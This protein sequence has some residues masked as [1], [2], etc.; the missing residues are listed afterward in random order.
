MKIHDYAKGEKSLLVKNDPYVGSFGVLWPVN[1]AVTACDGGWLKYNPRVV[2]NRVINRVA[3]SLVGVLLSYIEDFYSEKK[4]T[5]EMGQWIAAVGGKGRDMVFQFCVVGKEKT[6][7]LSE[8]CSECLRYLVAH[9][10]ANQAT[11]D[12]GRKAFTLAAEKVAFL[13]ARINDLQQDFS[14]CEIQQP[15][16]VETCGKH[17]EIASFRER[18]DVYTGVPREPVPLSGAAIV[19]GFCD[20]ENTVLLKMLNERGQ[21]EERPHRFVVVSAALIDVALEARRSKKHVLFKGKELYAIGAKKPTFHLEELVAV[22]EGS[23]Y[24]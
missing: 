6:P 2:N 18:F 4:V 10:Q 14:G 19:D 12:F 3:A 24:S 5:I 1:Q 20:S 15:F 21:A 13:D 22:K 7:E 9:L 11:L 23:V 17:N 8:E 16:G